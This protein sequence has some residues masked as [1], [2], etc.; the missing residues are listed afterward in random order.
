MELQYSDYCCANVLLQTDM[1]HVV[2]VVNT[3]TDLYLAELPALIIDHIKMTAKAMLRLAS[4]LSLSVLAKIASGA[5]A[6]DIMEGSPYPDK[7]A[8]EES[9]RRLPITLG[10]SCHTHHAH[11]LSWT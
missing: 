11:R 7:T 1:E 4:L 2:G 9:F 10:P 5:K 8:G 3:A 6:Y